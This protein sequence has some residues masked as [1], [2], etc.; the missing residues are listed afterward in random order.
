MSES[1]DNTKSADRWLKE[2]LFFQ[3][4][5]TDETRKIRQNLLL[6]AAVGLTMA[7]GG[8]FPKEITALGLKVGDID[9]RALII[10]LASI[11]GY[12]TTTYSLHIYSDF[13]HA[14][15]SEGFTFK[16]IEPEDE[17]IEK[18]STTEKYPYDSTHCCPS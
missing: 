2:A 8:I 7:A 10:I 15:W 5:W 3:D 16:T 17:D 6:L 13:M 18:D 11:L 9:R 4:P 14:Y 12:L 1:V